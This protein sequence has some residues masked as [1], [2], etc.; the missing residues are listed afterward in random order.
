MKKE[1]MFL[2]GLLVVGM[3]AFTACPSP[4]KVLFFQQDGNYVVDNNYIMQAATKMSATDIEELVRLDNDYFNKTQGKLI[5]TTTG[6]IRALAQKGETGQVNEGGKIIDP[7]KNPILIDWKGLL[8]RLLIHHGCLER[9]DIEWKQYGDLN[10]RF[11]AIIQKYNPAFLDGKVVIEGDRIVTAAA[12]I[13]ET[14]ASSLSAMTIKGM[15]ESDI[16]NEFGGIKH[17]NHVLIVSWYL[18]PDFQLR[19]KLNVVLSKYQ[20]QGK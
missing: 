1:S 6:F 16:C 10:T 8:Q 2:L 5:F 15:D 4:T 19:D 9:N 14:D 12:K 3:I 13:S 18:R 17:L 7:L 20:L 11:D